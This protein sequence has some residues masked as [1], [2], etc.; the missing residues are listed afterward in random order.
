M[1]A[2]EI[3]RISSAKKIDHRVEAPIGK[4]QKVRAFSAAANVNTL[5]AKYTAE[6]VVGEES[7]INFLINVPFKE[8]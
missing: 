6:R 4:G 1:V 5:A 3:G 8:F 2:G 7:K